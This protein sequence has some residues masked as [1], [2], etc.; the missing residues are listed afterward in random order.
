MQAQK[1]EEMVHSKAFREQMAEVQ[2]NLK[3]IEMP[4]IQE[5]ITRATA[6]VNSPEFKQQMADIQKGLN[7]E[8]Q[9]RMA[10]AMKQMKE[11]QEELKE[12]SPK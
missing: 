12:T 6:E 5:E 7:G 2:R 1:A 9:Q 3:T 10:E 11:A 8:I 4:R